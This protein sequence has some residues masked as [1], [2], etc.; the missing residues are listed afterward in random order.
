MPDTLSFGLVRYLQYFDTSC[1][2][3]PRLR[4]ILARHWPGS[5]LGSL[6]LCG[7]G[8]GSG[9]AFGQILHLYYEHTALAKTAVAQAVRADMYLFP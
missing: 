5:M 6:D 7:A 4:A 3:R 8:L 9:L 2:T 1:D